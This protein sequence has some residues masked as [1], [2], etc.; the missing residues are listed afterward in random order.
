MVSIILAA[1]NETKAEAI[2]AGFRETIV[3]IRH[4]GVTSTEENQKKLEEE[5]RK[6]RPYQFLAAD[7][8][9]LC[10]E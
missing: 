9:G 5:M 8:W 7:Y 6:M 1:S 2:K 4:N 10:A 3:L